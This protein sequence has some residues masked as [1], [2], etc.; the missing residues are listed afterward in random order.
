MLLLHCIYVWWNSFQVLVSL[1][2][3]TLFL[4]DACRQTFWEKLDD[5]LYYVR[6]FG[7]SVEFCFGILL[8]F[9]GAWILVFE[10]GKFDQLFFIVVL[11]SVLFCFHCLL[12]CSLLSFSFVDKFPCHRKFLVSN[13]SQNCIIM[14]MLR[15]TYINLFD[16]YMCIL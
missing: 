5:Y 15:G 4:L 14:I 13:I 3:Y 11:L 2:T 10:S 16:I 9:N 1:A 12:V 7:N 8:F 6:A